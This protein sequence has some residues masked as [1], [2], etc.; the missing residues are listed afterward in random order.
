MPTRPVSPKG[1]AC[2]NCGVELAVIG[3]RRRADM[4]V[5]RRRKCE[6]CDYRMTTEERL[7]RSSSHCSP[8]PLQPFPDALPGRHVGHPEQLAE[9]GVAAPVEHVQ[10]DQ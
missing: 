2:P 8:Q 7:K 10:L 9:G 6:L 3:T 1:F 4:V 5:S